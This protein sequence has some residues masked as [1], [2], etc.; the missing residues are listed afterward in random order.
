MYVAYIE[1]GVMTMTATQIDLDDDLLT[2]AM[3]TSG[4]KTKKAVVN[5]ALREYTERRGRAEARL[6]HFSAARGWSD[7]AFWAEHG[8]DKTLGDADSMA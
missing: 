7:A 5:V 3:K 1:D 6:R 8:A 2:A 4:A